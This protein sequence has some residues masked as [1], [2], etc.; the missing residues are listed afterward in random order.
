M[1]GTTGAGRKW[2]WPW[3]KLPL[4][5]ILKTTEYGEG[6]L[7][8]SK[9]VNQ[10]RLT[11]K[12]LARYPNENLGK[13]KYLTRSCTPFELHR[14]AQPDPENDRNHWRYANALEE[15]ARSYD[16]G[17][18][19][20]DDVR[21]DYD[22]GSDEEYIY[23]VGEDVDDHYIAPQDMSGNDY[24]NQRSRWF[25]RHM[26]HVH[27]L[28]ALRMIIGFYKY[29]V[30]QQSPPTGKEILDPLLIKA[31]LEY[32]RMMV[33]MPAGKGYIERMCDGFRKIMLKAQQ[34]R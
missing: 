8:G 29:F 9:K 3:P 34:V 23:E 19:S 1:K 31:V 6:L 12:A 20:G 27:A 2:E 14:G 7:I 21:A 4:E 24:I 11:A 10:L 28:S 26:I 25:R 13:P 22:V 32:L 30:R 17:D 16:S 15:Q 5:T 33:P 18:E